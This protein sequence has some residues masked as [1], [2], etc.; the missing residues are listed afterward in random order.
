MGGMRRVKSLDSFSII[1]VLHH[2]RGDFDWLVDR[3]II[4]WEQASSLRAAYR[5]ALLHCPRKILVNDHLGASVAYGVK[6]I[7]ISLSENDIVEYVDW[8]LSGTPITCMAGMNP[9]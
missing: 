3:R 4:S 2:D 8:L 7:E 6:A 5:S 9:L 1:H